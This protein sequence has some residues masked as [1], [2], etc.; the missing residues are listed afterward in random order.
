MT[1]LE[2]GTRDEQRRTAIV[3]AARECF[4]RFGYGK[5]SLDDI[6]KRANIS[7]PLIYRKFKNKEEIF[8][9][10]FDDLVA[11]LFPA[12]EAVVAGRGTKSEKLFGVYEIVLLRPWAEMS[13]AP[14]AAE[15][16]ETCSRLF[17]EV[18][19]KYD[20]QRAKLTHAII[21][22]RA[23]AEVFMLAVDGLQGDL[24]KTAVLRK[25]LQVLVDHFAV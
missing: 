19:E 23:V 7:R 21:G 18:E 11:G 2:D 9:A 15:F 20:T 25:R 14:M 10:V 17:P 4:L 3:R 22:S 8:V 6:A 16:Y 1:I 12:A 13:E 5:T 24:P